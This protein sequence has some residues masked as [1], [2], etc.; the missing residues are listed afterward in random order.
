MVGDTHKSG[1]FFS[2]D[3]YIPKFWIFLDGKLFK[4]SQYQNPTTK[5]RLIWLYGWAEGIPKVTDWPEDK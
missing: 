1:F 4:K 3:Y 2:F 5:H